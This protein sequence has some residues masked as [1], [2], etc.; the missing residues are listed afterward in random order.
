FFSS[1]LLS[2]HSPVSLFALDAIAA[3]A[4]YTPSLHDALPIWARI[5][6]GVG[7][8][9]RRNRKE[10]HTPSAP[11]RR[12]GRLASCRFHSSLG[13]QATRSEERRVG[14]ERRSRW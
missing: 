1:M 14:K 8:V 7:P 3:S 5:S 9:P 13:Q 10:K 6:T 11:R 4:P 2:V 12:A